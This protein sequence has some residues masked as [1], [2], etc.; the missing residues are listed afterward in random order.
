MKNETQAPTYQLVSIQV[1]LPQT[2]NFEGQTWTSG[3]NKS[4]VQTA[5]VFLTKTHFEG[6]A[7]AD[8]KNHG[9]VDKAVCVYAYDHYPFWEELLGKPLSPGAFGENVTVAG[10]LE[11]DVCIGDIFQ[12]G[13]ALVQVSQPRQPCHKLAKKHEWADL[14]QQFEQTGRTGF[15]FRVLQ[16]GEVAISDQLIQLEQHPEQLTVAFA[17]RIMHHEKRNKAGIEKLLAVNE[18]SASWRTTL[19]KRLDTII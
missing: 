9:G 4:P 5:S 2:Y 18:L 7:Q 3:I 8:L 10:L 17:N 13:S 15:Y 19:S 11:T 14:P 16:E 1:G 12:L 6:D